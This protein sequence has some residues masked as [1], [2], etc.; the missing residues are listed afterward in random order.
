MIF[1]WE[2][3]G[4]QD[5]GP[6]KYSKAGCFFRCHGVIFPKGETQGMKNYNKKHT[7]DEKNPLT[8]IRILVVS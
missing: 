1:N 4:A 6:S 2:M 5:I 8:F 7:R 3:Y